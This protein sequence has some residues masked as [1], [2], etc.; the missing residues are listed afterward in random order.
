M[1]EKK[2]EVAILNTTYE[3]HKKGFALDFRDPITTN[4][5]AGRTPLD[6]TKLKV[7]MKTLEDAIIKLGSLSRTHP[8]YTNKDVVL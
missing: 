2:E 8:E 3:I 5:L 6:Y 1:L 7:G 4:D